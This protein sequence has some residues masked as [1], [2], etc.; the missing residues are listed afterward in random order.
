VAGSNRDQPVCG[1]PSP[2]IGGA[3]YADR[4]IIPQAFG[5]FDGGNRA[6]SRRGDLPRLA[7]AAIRHGEYVVNCESSHRLSE[8]WLANESPGQR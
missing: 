3:S 8:D 1:C 2:H 7:T 4:G 5:S 6:D